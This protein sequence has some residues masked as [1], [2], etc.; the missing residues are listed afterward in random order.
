MS[1]II[2]FVQ[3]L[4]ISFHGFSQST[5]NIDSTKSKVTFKI[6]GPLGTTV[7]GAFRSPF[8]KIEIDPSTLQSSKFDIKITA[9]TINTSNKKR[10]SHLKNEEFFDVAKYPFITFTSDKIEKSNS[11]FI[12]SGVL[13]I[14]NISKKIQISFTM[15]PQGK[16]TNL[17][18]TIT[19]NRLEYEV[20]KSSYLVKDEA[21]VMI[22]VFI[23]R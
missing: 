2:V 14:K 19:I 15:Q 1:K 16:T 5:W 3:L 18:G 13:K 7:D 22:D 20:G 9:T 11:G 10:D 12:A 8:G 4:I 21:K 23:I 6:G 17:K